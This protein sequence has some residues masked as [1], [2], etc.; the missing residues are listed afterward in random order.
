MRHRCNRVTSPT[1]EDDIA[2]DVVLLPDSTALNAKGYVLDGWGGLHPFG[3]APAVF[4][5]PYFPGRDLAKRM[6]LLGDGSGGYVLDAY[7]GLHPFTI[8]GHTRPRDITNHAYFGGFD[9]AR[10][11]VLLPN[12]TGTSAAGVTLDGYGGLHPFDN[13]TP[14]TLPTDYPYFRGFDIA[15]AIRLMPGTSLATPQGWILDGFGGLHPFGGA[16]RMMDYPYFVGND[17]AKQLTV[18]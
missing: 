9:I 17:V 12:S 18:Q 14:V 2:R 15:R 3:G 6:A 8:A 11:F 10:D 5:Y 4:D 16:P 7:G 1:S 13:G